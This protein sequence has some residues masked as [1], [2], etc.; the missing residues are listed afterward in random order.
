MVAEWRKLGTK[1]Q[2]RLLATDW[3][4]CGRNPAWPVDRPFTLR[5]LAEDQLEI[6]R[7]RGPGPF[8]LVGH[9]LGG[10]IALQMLAL[11]PSL[12]HRA[13]LLDPV[14]AKGV[15]FDDRMYDAFKQMAASPELTR[16]VI[17][18]TI[19]G[20]ENLERHLADAFAEDAFKAVKGI[21]SSVLEILKTVDLR[22][23]A[24]RVRVPT[25]ILH[26]AKDAVIPLADARDLA[27]TMPTATLEILPDQGHCYNVENPKAFAARVR[28]WLNDEV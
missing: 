4:G 10:L 8:D 25:L 14:G 15:I 6:L 22:A 28:S 26:G 18:S 23:E 5:D 3:R 27:N 24:A 20:A 12:F 7:A 17:L 16:T 13:V 1:G 9:S 19:L 21:G 2:G 11:E